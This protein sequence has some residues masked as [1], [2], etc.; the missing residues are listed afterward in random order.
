M[1]GFNQWD[2]KLEH[3][4]N[5][6]K[7]KPGALAGSTAMHQANPRLTK[8]YK[9]YYTKREK[10]FIELLL[11]LKEKNIEEVETAIALLEK[12]SPLDITTEKIKSICNRNNDVNVINFSFGNDTEKCETTIKSQ[13]MLHD[14][15]SLIPDSNEKFKEEVGII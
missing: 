3:Y 15:K 14:F 1:H 2:I 9:E 10:D 4:L 5:T 11:F 6:L 8:I 12:V 13:E 7:K